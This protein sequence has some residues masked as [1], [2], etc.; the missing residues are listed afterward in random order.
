MNFLSGMRVEEFTEEHCKVSVPFKWLNQNPFRSTF[1]AVLGMTAELAAGA[2]V[3]MYTHKQKP[4]ISTLVTGSR[5]KFVKKAVKSTTFVC[6][7]GLMIAEAVRKAVETGEG[8]L[9]TCRS[10][11]YNPDGEVVAEFEFD[12]SMKARSK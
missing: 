5:A 6:N 1:W 11:G 10:V 9:I 7:D 12:W 8:Q 3:V 2:M 4:S